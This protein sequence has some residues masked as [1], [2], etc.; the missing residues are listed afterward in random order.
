M[1]IRLLD[2]PEATLTPDEVEA[3]ANEEFDYADRERV[4]IR[5]AR[6]KIIQEFEDKRQRQNLAEINKI[7]GTTFDV[8][9]PYREPDTLTQ[10][11]GDFTLQEKTAEAAKSFHRGL[12]SIVKLP[13]VLLK[14]LGETAPTRV[15][16]EELK[17][18]PYAIQRFREKF[19]RTP[20]GKTQRKGMDM[21]RRAG[22]RYIEIVNGM[23]TDESAESR[24]V[25][26]GAFLNDPFY[27][28]VMAVGESAPTYGLAVAATLTSGNPNIGLLILGSTTASSSYDSLRQQG[29]DP[30]LAIIGALLEGSIEMVTEKIPMNM[31]M[32]GAGRRFL[33]RALR[34]GTAE[35]FQELFAQLGQ[36]YVNA[37]V[38]DVDPE[39]YST[40]V[41]AARQEWDIISQGWEDAMAAGFVMGSGAGAF[42]GGRDFGRTA[43]EMQADYGIA[44]QNPAELMAM[45][46]IIRQEVRAVEPFEGIL[47]EAAV[48]GDT[49]DVMLKRLQAEH[50]AKQ[51]VADRT[52]LE[53]AEREQFPELARQEDQIGKLRAAPVAEPT[54][55]GVVVPPTEAKRVDL[56]ILSKASIHG[57]IIRISV[58][59]LGKIPAVE[60]LKKQLE[61][62][63][64]RITVQKFQ[65]DIVSG[66]QGVVNFRIDVG[67]EQGRASPDLAQQVFESKIG[68]EEFFRQKTALEREIPL[69][70]RFEAV[71]KYAVGRLTG[72]KPSIAEQRRAEVGR[73]LRAGEEVSPRLRKEFAALVTE[74]EGPVVIIPEV[75]TEGVGP[76]A[77]AQGIPPSKEIG[78]GEVKPRGTSVSVVAQAI[79][80]ELIEENKPL[81]DELP[82]YRAMNMK[83]QAEKA[84]AV[85]EAD[86]EQAKR[87]AFYQEPAPPDLF[88]ENV[89]TALRIYAKMSADVDLI[90]DLALNEDAVREH[91]IM[92][93]RIKSLDTDQDYADPVRAI[94]EIVVARKDGMNRKG[95]DISAL[96]TKLREL[97]A[98]LDRTKRAFGEHTIRAKREYGSRNKVVTRTEYDEII[99]RRKNEIPVL[100]HDPRRGAAYVPNTQ[101]FVDIAKI[102][103]FHIEALGRDFAKWSHQMTR[104]FGKWITPHLQE[105]YD[106]VVAQAE[107]EGVELKEAKRLTA[108]KK[109]LVTVTKKLEAK[110]AGRDLEKVPRLP[111]ELDEEGRRLQDAY[112]LAREK[113]RAAQAVANIITEE[114]VRIIARFAQEAS[115]RKIT[116]EQSKRRTEGKPATK[117]EME[118]GIAMSLFLEYVDDLKAE[119]NKRTMGR[120]IK[121]YLKNPVDFISDFFGTLK[122][123][124]A[125]LDDSFLLRQGLPTFLKGI[126][127][128]IPS[129]VIWWK[130]FFR[131]WKFMWDTLRKKKVM[132]MLFAEI[133]SDPDYDLL[134]KAKVALNVIEEEI[135]VDIPSRIPLVGILFRMGENAF[136]GSSRYMRYQLAKQYLSVWR[137]SG[138]ELTKRELESIGKL[139]NSQTGRGDTAARS[140]RPGLLNNV[141]W[142]PR[143][144]R[145]SIDILTL[146]LF[147]RNFTAFA[148]RQAA[149][150]LLRYISGTAM[151]LA[152]AK[153]VDDDSVTWEPTN[154][155]FGKIVIGNTRFSVGG[156]HGVL[157]VLAS[158]LITR[159]FTS[160][161]T[162]KTVTIDSR[163]FGA[164]GGKDLVFNFLDNKLSPGAAL[165]ISI[166]D[167]KTW[168][169]DQLR[170]PQMIDDALTPLLIQNV[171]ETGSADDSANVLAA[172]IAEAIGVNVQTYNNDRKKKSK[173]RTRF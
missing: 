33:I 124:K 24:G 76:V 13:G 27:R 47:E 53:P 170:I 151:I 65:T 111:I 128:H 23:M 45:I 134:K 28:T 54:P 106:K 35:S 94:R 173:A 73:R 72:A 49:T 144:L 101:D 103:M 84:L 135:P 95:V 20:V 105:E 104:D 9:P 155:D 114:E 160:S 99:N 102:G 117:K 66:T 48:A 113:Y 140:Q 41:Q 38:K 36:N 39:D 100:R 40:A 85:I 126:T 93:K 10:G 130:T 21:I 11:Y 131:S 153:W 67:D 150:N 8:T 137:K 91:T 161:T 169:G 30:D 141:F 133:V 77:E 171:I 71:R 138:K 44:P 17:K 83:E 58:D 6:A 125:S 146:H 168:K 136:V 162:G 88:P 143:N 32:S 52:P 46:E 156:S 121:D 107:K 142:S 116:M 96:E 159:K 7:F 149:I 57:D 68:T 63:G 108:K 37:V 92:G 154:A 120:V 139:A 34:L 127:G 12:G 166:I 164:L 43:E 4:S 55:E 18:S 110:L 29:V 158:R 157:V 50:D 79:E 167:Q 80:A 163:K 172:L 119:A 64:T 59:A 5:Q 86:V 19:L 87:I 123:A 74:I 70:E 69:E 62:E 60:E 109:R 98:E 115:E 82:T 31:L 22:N 3:L 2:I 165:A 56:P 118:Y 122:A 132:R 14:A 81:F 147:D 51:K 1:A 112:D 78:K 42:S 16:I 148:R 145:A 61:I 15:E 25:R 75:K 129:A 97:Q 89:F 90:M 152:L 26:Q